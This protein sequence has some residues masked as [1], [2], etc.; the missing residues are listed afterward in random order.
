VARCCFIF[1]DVDDTLLEWRVSWRESFATAAREVG[2]EVSS[3]EAWRAVEHAFGTYYNDCLA[4]YAASD[5]ETAFW[6]AYDGRILGDLG[7]PAERVPQAAERVIG[8]L[9]RPEAIR[10]YEEVPE[11]LE[12][13]SERGIRLGIV[14]G[15]PKAE[16]DLHLLGV[17]GYFDPVI[18]AFSVGSSKSVGR[19]FHVAAKA[20]AEAG[21]P[22]WHVGDNYADDILGARAAGL[23]AVLIDRKRKRKTNDCPCISDLRDLIS[24]VLDGGT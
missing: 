8:L 21:L 15:R 17:R 10:L 14:T 3:E 12:A 13:L 6:R 20:A 24:I 22:G 4:D 5:D 18:D 2:I 19:M 23:K 9:K 7:V 16:P 1:F 11:V